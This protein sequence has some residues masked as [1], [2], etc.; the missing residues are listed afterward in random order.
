MYTNKELDGKGMLLSR[1]KE[2][3]KSKILNVALSSIA[4]LV[5]FFI[6][7]YLDIVNQEKV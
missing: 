6:S 4:C 5:V 7:L 2:T 1:P 3:M